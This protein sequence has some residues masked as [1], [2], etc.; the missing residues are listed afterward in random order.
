MVI[1]T[2]SYNWSGSREKETENIIKGYII[3]IPPKAQGS[4]NKG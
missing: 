3:K 4:L 2:V 1:S